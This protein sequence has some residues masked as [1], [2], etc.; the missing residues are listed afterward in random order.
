LNGRH[1]GCSHQG[2]AEAMTDNISVFCNKK[3]VQSEQLLPFEDIIEL[4]AHTKA[5][6]YNPF[7]A[8]KAQNIHYELKNK[9]GAAGRVIAPNVLLPFEYNRFVLFA[10]GSLFYCFHTPR[11]AIERVLKLAMIKGFVIKNVYGKH[12]IGTGYSYSNMEQIVEN[13]NNMYSDE[14][15]LCFETLLSQEKFIETLY[16]DGNI[17]LTASKYENI[18]PECRQYMALMSDGRFLVAEE[19]ADRYGIKDYRKIDAFYRQHPEYVYLQKEYVPQSYINAIYKKA[20]KFAWFLPAE[21]FVD[22][23]T[24]QILT[25][26]ERLKMNI[27]IH[28]LLAGGNKCLSVVCP[29]ERLFYSPDN[30]KYAL[31]ADGRLLLD[32]RQLKITEDD[33]LVEIKKYFSALNLHLERVPSYYIDEIYDRLRKIQKSAGEIYLEILKQKAKKLKTM[34]KI[35]HHEALELSAKMVGW[36]N[37]KE[38]TSVDEK[39]ARLAIHSEKHNKQTAEKFGVNQIE[40]EYNQYMQK[41]E[42]KK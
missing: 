37:W 17:C 40:Y 1:Q 36:K 27:F 41:K 22:N 30:L 39:L 4:L 8:I 26:E 28:R 14:K 3:L 20:E 21:Q 33:L 29:S 24:K 9:A 5:V 11:E 38:A 2:G 31:F 42:N 35:P 25:D 15:N 23:K 10:D 7:Y 19:Y 18:D 13:L 32:E 16:A 6:G 12:D 34:L